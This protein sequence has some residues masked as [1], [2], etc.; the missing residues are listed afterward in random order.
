MKIIEILHTICIIDITNIITLAACIRFIL[1]KKNVSMRN[2]KLN[3]LPRHKK[4]SNK[5]NMYFWEILG[6]NLTNMAPM[7]KARNSS[8]TL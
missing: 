7:L 5:L 4:G 2:P 3:L 1:D 6:S 8:K